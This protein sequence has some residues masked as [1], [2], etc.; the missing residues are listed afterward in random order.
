MSPNRRDHLR[1]ALYVKQKG[2]C[3]R[4]RV[5]LCLELHRANTMHLDHVNPRS[6]GGA[7]EAF[8]LEL[9]CQ[10]CNYSKAA[11]LSAGLQHTLFDGPSRR[12][13]RQPP[14]PQSPS[15]KGTAEEIGTITRAL[16][17]K[18]LPGSVW[19]DLHSKAVGALTA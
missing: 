17:V 19:E 3:C 12:K 16:S 14:A 9:V 5:K 11:N 18:K 1:L 2:R 7:D 6:N 15:R 4:C 8:N 10:A 13:Q